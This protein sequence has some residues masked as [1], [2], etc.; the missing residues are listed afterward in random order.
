MED[1]FNGEIEIEDGGRV[2]SNIK[3]YGFFTVKIDGDLQEGK[4]DTLEVLIHDK[5]KSSDGSGFMFGVIPWEEDFPHGSYPGQKFFSFASHGTVYSTNNAI[6]GGIG[7]H[8]CGNWGTGDRLK[9][10]LDPFTGY[11]TLEV[12]DINKLNL[13]LNI[14]KPVCFCISLYYL[15]QK[16]EILF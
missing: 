16:V 10:N 11:F 3:E 7:S 2:I 8:S 13:K 14:T 1:K 9:L 5:G 4:N 15:T 6:E 12:N